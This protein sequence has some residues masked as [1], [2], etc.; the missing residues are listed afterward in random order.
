MLSARGKLSESNLVVNIGDLGC[1]WPDEMD[2][3]ALMVQLGVQP[4]CKLVDKHQFWLIILAFLS[5]GRTCC[6]IGDEEP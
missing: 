2:S 3:S 6:T 1:A 5:R 4:V